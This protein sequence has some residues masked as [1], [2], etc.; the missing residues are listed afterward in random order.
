MEASFILTGEYEEE[1]IEGVETFKY[2][3]RM[4]DSGIMEFQEGAT[5]MDLA[6]ETAK[7]RGGGP[8]SVRNVLLGSGASGVTL[9]GGDLSFVGGNVQK[10]GGGARGFPYTGDRSEFQ[11]EEGR[12]MEKRD[13]GK[14]TEVGGN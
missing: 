4:L 7:E 9:W 14:D 12:D 2:L 6:R 13:R 8:A 10:S 5:S 3:G 11:A 1:C